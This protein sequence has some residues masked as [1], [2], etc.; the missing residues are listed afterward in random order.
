M[1]SESNSERIPVHETNSGYQSSYYSSSEVPF[2]PRG[3][4]RKHSS[5]SE[6][7]H[8][9]R[10]DTEHE[11]CERRLEGSWRQLKKCQTDKKAGEKA[12]ES[13]IDLLRIRLFHSLREG[14][15][16]EEAEKVYDETV[17]KYDDAEK[18]HHQA[19]PGSEPT[20]NQDT[21]IH[22]LKFSFA[23]MLIE[24]EKQEKF[25]QAEPISRAVWEKRE[26]RP[27]PPSEDYKES[28]RQLC[29]I[30]CALGR[31]KDAERMH[32]IIYQKEEKDTWALENGDEMCQRLRE[33]GQIKRAKEMQDDVW[34]ERLRQ[35][36]PRDELTIRSG[37]RLI[38]YLMELV[39]TIDQ[40]GTDAERRLNIIHRQAFECEIEVNL[41]KIWNT[42][43]HPERNADILDAGHE[44]GKVLFH[45]TKFS[46]AE[47]IFI[48]VWEGKKEQRGDSDISTMSTGSMLGKVLHLQGSQQNYHRAKDILRP[49]WL[50]SQKVMNGD[51]EAM[52]SG[53]YLAQ[54]YRSLGAWSDAEP[55][56]RWILE[57][58]ERK[59][60]CPTR[61]IDNARWNLAQTLYSQGKTK[62]REAELYLGELYPRWNASLPD[63]R[64]TSQ[65]GHMLA[66]SLSTQ[67]GKTEEA[68]KLAL[69]IFDA[70]AKAKNRG[71]DYLDSGR[72][73]GSLLLEVGD[74]AEA[75]RI[76]ESVWA[77]Q[78]EEIE[79][80]KMRL[81]CGHLYGQALAKRHKNANAK[82]ILEVVADKQRGI[83]PAGDP[84]I[85]ET[86]QLLEEVNR[87][88]KENKKVKRNSGRRRGIGIFV[89]H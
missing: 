79:E 59:H 32:M 58:K 38:G 27:G 36:G 86:R 87:P 15:K 62:D 1:L 85:A 33:Q 80:Q 23:A 76:L 69:V 41:R 54:T 8:Y 56:H 21:A 70:R 72:L 89:G 25:Q 18:L 71:V 5:S 34:I 45:Q 2:K 24:Q 13:Q 29:L 42:R 3:S 11:E 39:A 6:G 88:E 31:H 60:G 63:S 43:L 57:Q 64:V 51:A 48:P 61:E 12:A 46:D 47:A 66:Q 10:T 83:L 44:L 81:K 22:N 9:N 35:H 49:I 50:V 17:K 75:E 52:S 30:L 65:C 19:V 74:F 37:L 84:Q 20:E 14:G 26:Q 40:G 28:H 77:H 78:A 7:Y 53:E 55:V 73:Y 68:R 4:G 16:Y 82:G 67:E